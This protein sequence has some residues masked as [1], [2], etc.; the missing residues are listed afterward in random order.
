MLASPSVGRRSFCAALGPP[1]G[2]QSALLVPRG[3]RLWVGG[4]RWVSCDLRWGGCPD[5]C[6]AGVSDV[7]GA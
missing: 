5:P 3:A 7:P 4:R 2:G 1:F 6:E